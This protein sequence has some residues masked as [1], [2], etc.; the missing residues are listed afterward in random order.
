MCGHG[1]YAHSPTF[2]CDFSAHV[3]FHFIFTGFVCV[4]KSLKCR[5]KSRRYA[6]FTTAREESNIFLIAVVFDP[7]TLRLTRGHKSHESLRNYRIRVFLL[8]VFF[9]NFI[10][11]LRKVDIWIGCKRTSLKQRP[12]CYGVMAFSMQLH[13]AW[14]RS[15][16]SY[17]AVF[18]YRC[19]YKS[20]GKTNFEMNEEVMF[21]GFI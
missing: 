2:D 9:S 4:L 14:V 1:V 3:Y 21:Y 11:I 10:L 7:P 5:I 19:I 16:K 18:I 8:V 12:Y 6:L 17:Q 15:H 13:F 20:Q